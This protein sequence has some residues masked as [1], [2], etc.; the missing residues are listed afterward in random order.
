MSFSSLPKLARKQIHLVL[1]NAG[2]HRSPKVVWPA[3]I[4]PRFLPPYSPELNPVEPLWP[5][6]RLCGLSNSVL[7]TGQAL[8]DR[9]CEAWNRITTEDIKSTCRVPW[10]ERGK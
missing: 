9:G 3:N 10:L 4:T 7:P 6:V 5:R 1:D 2:W 8:Q